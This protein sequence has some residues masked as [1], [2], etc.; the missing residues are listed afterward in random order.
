MLDYE[1]AGKLSGEPQTYKTILREK[2]GRNTMTTILSGRMNELVHNGL[3]CVTLMYGSRNNE[4]MFFSPKKKYT[5]VFRRS[6]EG[7]SYYHCARAHRKD[8][9]FVLKKAFELDV[10]R[11]VGVGDMSFNFREVVKCL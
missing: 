9:E 2:Y 3:A 5:L 1:L 7:C 10:D 4:R 8:G 6:R 11:W